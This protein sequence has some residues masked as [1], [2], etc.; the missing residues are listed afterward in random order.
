M[1]RKIKCVCVNFDFIEFGGMT[2]RKFWY[3]LWC[4]S[5]SFT[6]IRDAFALPPATSEPVHRGRGFSLLLAWPTAGVWSLRSG[7]PRLRLFTNVGLPFHEALRQPC[8]CSD[9][10]LCI[11]CSTFHRS[12]CTRASLIRSTWLKCHRRW[13]L[14]ALRHCGTWSPRRRL[15][16]ATRA[17]AAA[18]LLRSRASPRLHPS[19]SSSSKLSVQRR[20]ELSSVPLQEVWANEQ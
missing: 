4:R 11:G 15:S 9:V 2:Q 13:L 14:R 5:T 7:S 18:A 6:I 19:P 20:E 16:S 12:V 10:L 1:C 3:G 8:T 17:A